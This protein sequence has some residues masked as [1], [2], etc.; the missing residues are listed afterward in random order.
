MRERKKL[1]VRDRKGYWPGKKLKNKILMSSLQQG[2]I[3]STQFEA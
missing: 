3:I 2:K 1:E